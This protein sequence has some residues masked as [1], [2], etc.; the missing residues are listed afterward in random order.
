[1][2]I[3]SFQNN[4]H[5]WAAFAQLYHFLSLIFVLPFA[6]LTHYRNGSFH[7][8]EM[9]VAV[10]L[11]HNSGHIS[12]L[13]SSTKIKVIMLMMLRTNGFCLYTLE[14]QAL[15]GARSYVSLRDI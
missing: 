15:K 14:F 10:Y 6:F 13:R 2:R 9:V 4:L 11:I 8:Y 1:M 7:Q 12:E 3:R 5:E